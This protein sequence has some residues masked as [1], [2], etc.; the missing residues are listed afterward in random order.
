MLVVFKD[1]KV[2]YVF[3]IDTEYDND[4]LMQFAGL[5]FHQVDKD[6]EVYQLAASL[7]TYIYKETVNYYASKFTGITAEFLQEKGVSIEEL[8]NNLGDIFEEVEPKEVLLVSHGV[9]ND[10]KVLK[11]AGIKFLPEH[12]YCTYKNS[13]KLLGRKKNLK[14][15]DVANE[16]GFFIGDKSHDAFADAWATTSVFCFLT[17]IKN[18]M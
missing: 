18:E 12:S 9:K 10:R 6:N 14:L 17:K 11:K 15:Q 3:I 16:S 2:P 5:L 1:V 7:N 4:G 8:N 13:K